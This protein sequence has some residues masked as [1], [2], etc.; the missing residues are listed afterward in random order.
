ME[1]GKKNVEPSTTSKKVAGIE[2]NEII[3]QSKQLNF[4]LLFLINIMPI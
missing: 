1:K 2:D 3:S 4:Q